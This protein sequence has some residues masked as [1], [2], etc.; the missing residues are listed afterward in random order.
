MVIIFIKYVYWHFTI[1]PR[2]ILVIMG[3][4]TKANWHKFLIGQH[5]KTLFAPWHRQDPSQI[6]KKPSE[7]SDIILNKIVDVYIR[8]VAAVI[9]L[10]VIVAGLFIEVLIFTGFLL[11]LAVWIIWPLVAILAVVKGLSMIMPYVF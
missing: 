4:Y 6:G 1:A 8:L 5:F 10:S 2:E 3:N 11:L 7:I 9:R